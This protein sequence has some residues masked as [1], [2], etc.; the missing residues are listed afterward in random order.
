MKSDPR[1]FIL[2]DR[3]LRDTSLDKTPRKNVFRVGRR[4]FT[5]DENAARRCGRGN[6]PMRYS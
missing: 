2:P 5:R 4:G 6:A 3:N 1:E